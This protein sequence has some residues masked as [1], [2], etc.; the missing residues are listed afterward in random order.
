MLTLDHKKLNSEVKYQVT[1]ASGIEQTFCDT[2]T[3]RLLSRTYGR[4]VN[5]YIKDKFK[6][7]VWNGKSNISK[8]IIGKDKC[9]AYV[10][11][12]R[13]KGFKITE[14]KEIK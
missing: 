6:I 9:R 8:T 14:C 4:I 12:Q 10:S 1:F 7:T 11:A 13:A 5:I 3:P 2:E